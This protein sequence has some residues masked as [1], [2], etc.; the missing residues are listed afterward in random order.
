MKNILLLSAYHAA[1][2]E[3][4]CKGLQQYFNQWQWHQESLPDRYFSWR[5]RGNSLTWGLGDY[6][7]L[8]HRYDLIVA[9]SMVDLATL[10]GLRPNLAQTPAVVYYHENQ[11]AYPKTRLQQGLIDRQLTSLYTALTADGIVFNSGF[12]KETFINGA[13][14]F[15]ASMP[16]AVPKGVVERL[17]DR[18][19]VIPVPLEDEL[20]DDRNT[21]N[22][23]A[24]G[25]TRPVQLLWNHRWEWDKGPDRL[26]AGFRC[27]AE[28]N[29]L[30]NKFV[31][32][33]VGQQFRQQ[34][35]E[36]TVLKALLAENSA[37]GHWGYVAS[38]AQYHQLMKQCQ[39]VISTALHDFQ[40]LAVLEAVASGNRPIVPNRLVYPEWFGD[41]HCY[42]SYDD[43]SKEAQFFAAHLLDLYYP[44]SSE[45][46]A[47]GS[48]AAVMSPFDDVT[49]QMRW[50][51]L[52]PRYHDVFC[53][54]AGIG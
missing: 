45:L 8:D 11:F 24:S 1:S 17:L 50:S 39:G 52:G 19:S 48:S 7:A 21:L 34:P 15:L 35:K 5:S 46:A 12:N 27:L 36:F 30:Q 23:G 51:V 20:I 2:H 47:C 37:L 14:Q 4:W 22:C 29:A 16:D 18:S 9:T 49:A 31:L 41:K 33:V 44:G 28:Q 32:H 6:P 40:G 54:A 43:I 3:R 42:Q 10:R 53:A 25:D 38:R 26:L 13:R